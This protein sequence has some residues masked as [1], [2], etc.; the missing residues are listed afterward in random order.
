MTAQAVTNLILWA[1]A[2]FWIVF[3]LNRLRAYRWI[4]HLP[5]LDGDAGT[6]APAR[7]SV[8]VAARN[9]ED[10]IE[11]TVR[12]MLGQ[13][14]VEIE[15]VIV[16]D[17]STDRTSEILRSLAGEDDRVR[18][19]RV[20]AVAPGWLGKVR[21]CHLGAGKATG[22]WLLFSDADAWMQPDLVA[23]SVQ[24]AK[25]HA[26]DHVCL[27]PGQIRPSLMGKAVLTFFSL[28]VAPLVARANRDRRLSFAGVGAYNMV[29]RE[30]YRSVGGHERL[31]LE[32]I[33]D[34]KLGVLLRR[35]GHRTRVFDAV[36]DLEIEWAADVPGIVR[37]LEKN[38][39]ASVRFRLDVAL[40]LALSQM[41]VWAAGMA[42]PFIGTAAGIAAG[43]GLLSTSL[44]GLVVARRA[45]WSPAVAL[46]C[47]LMLPVMTDSLLRSTFTTLARGGVRWRETFYPLDALR[48]GLVPWFEWKR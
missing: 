44:P 2:A 33:D 35:A 4:P 42:G 6:D 30:A 25:R 36:H 3:T 11:N 14:G 20:D 45:G 29:K 5:A 43:V 7:V 37:A 12:R 38:M 18:V 13:V 47:P 34:V 46:L 9:E 24:A 16:D 15:A 22:D 17:R 8:V 28:L 39:F 21:A 31:K 19:I 48:H 1:T 32:I 41:T 40:L 26:A 23:R 10:R 27:Y